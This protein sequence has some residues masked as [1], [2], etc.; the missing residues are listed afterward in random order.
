MKKIVL[1]L[2]SVFTLHLAMAQK[3]AVEVG[4][5]PMYATKN[6]V[7]N[8]SNS[9]DHTTLVAAVKAAGL[10][11]KLEGPGPF[12]VFAP[13]NAAFEKLPKG[14]MTSLVRPENRPTLVKILTYHMVSGRWEAKDIAR[15]VKDG[16]GTATLK[17][18]SGGTLVAK[19]EGDRMLLTD[20]KGSISTVIIK[21]VNQS[22]GIIHVIDTV[23]MPQ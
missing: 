7:E 6:I 14:T 1:A 9:N 2:L 19:M 21:N 15:M 4:G 13:T 16:G 3:D 22:N 20:E 18:V 11:T 10:V 5:A 23:L 8:A 17:T 12:T